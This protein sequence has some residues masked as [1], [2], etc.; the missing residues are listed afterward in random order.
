MTQAKE[1]TSYVR[2]F[3]QALFKYKYLYL[4]LLPAVV[5][6]ILFCY[7]PMYGVIIAFKKYTFNGGIWGSPWIGL[8][9]FRRA[10]STQQFW[11]AVRNTLYIS[12]GRLVFVFPAPIILALLLNE[13]R[14][15]AFKRTIQTMLYLPHFVSWIVMAGIIASL[16]TVNGGMINKIVVYFGGQATSFL[17]KPEWFRPI[18]FISNIMKEMGWSAIIYLA[19]LAG[20][21]PEL[22]EAAIVDGASRWQRFIFVTWPML[23]KT[24]SIT[25]ILAMG[26]LMSGGF[27][28]VFNLYNQAVFSVADVIETY[29]YRQTLIKADFSFGT[30]VGLFQSVINCAILLTVNRIMKITTGNNLY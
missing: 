10:F 2:S 18:V 27:D 6:Y 17:T 13:V 28:Q 3:F 7:M 5:W 14:I 16:T 25:L 1:L 22:Y 29:V 30:A 24:I 4:L 20:I 9:H 26:N 23:L 11:I 15:N 12:V 8:T 19:A 21:D